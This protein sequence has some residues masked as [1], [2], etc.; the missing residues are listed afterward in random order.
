MDLSAELLAAAEEVKD[1]AM[2]LVGNSARGCNLYQIGE[3]GSAIQHLEKAL[4]V[5]DLR[6]PLPWELEFSWVTSLG[7][8]SSGPY[9]LGYPERAWA[10]S[11]EMLEVAQRSSVPYVLTVASHQAAQ[12]NLVRGGGTAAPQHAQE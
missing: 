12:Q 1:P 10:K 5:F 11:R 3:L 2:L 7:Y 4:A 9:E 8:L 6:Q